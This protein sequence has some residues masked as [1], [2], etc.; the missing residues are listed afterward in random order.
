MIAD[1]YKH[2]FIDL[3]KTIWDFDRNARA[4]F[5]EIFDIYDLKSRG[6]GSSEEFMAVYTR[7]N[8]MLWGLYRENKIKKEVLSIR[9]FEMTLNEFG[10]DDLILATHIAEDYVTESPLKTI[11]L[12]YARQALDYLKLR[13]ELHL[14][15]N[16][17]EEVQHTK[18]D[19]SDLRKYFRTITTSEEAGVKKPE[20]PIFQLALKKAGA[21]AGES[22]MIGD[23]LAVDMAGA[24]ETGMDTLFFNPEK[25]P[26]QEKVDHEVFSWEEIMKI[27]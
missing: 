13:Y 22:L 10:I 14:I 1:R 18:L 12:P 16:G 3:D 17:F 2:I 20:A 27:L 6:I 7:I 4:T 19:A 25:A 11:L 9:R 21:R 26:H 5:D 23:D 8:D 15:T 24:R